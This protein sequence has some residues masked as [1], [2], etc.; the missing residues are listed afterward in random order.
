MDIGYWIGWVGVLGGICVP[1]PQLIK[2]I[3]TRRLED[4]SLGTYSILI[5]VLICY[6]WHAIYISAEVFIVA[7]S[8]NLISNGTIW[9]LLLRNKRRRND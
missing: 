6:L 3:R 4:I 5:F 8:L 7:Q 9:F 1:L 2:I